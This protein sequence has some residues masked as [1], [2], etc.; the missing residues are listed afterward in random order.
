MSRAGGLP[1]GRRRSLKTVPGHVAGCAGMFLLIW[2]GLFFIQGT[3]LFS[4]YEAAA[5]VRTETAAGRA[6]VHLPEEDSRTTRPGIRMKNQSVSLKKAGMSGRQGGNSVSINSEESS[7]TDTRPESDMRRDTEHT[8]DSDTQPETDLW[9]ETEELLSQLGMSELDAYLRHENI[10]QL[11]FSQLVQDLLRK[12]ISM[13]FSSIGNKIMQIV[14][15]DYREN[16]NAL[17]QIITLALAFS[18]ILQMTGSMQTSCL[19][20]LGFLG[21]YLILMLLLLKLFLIMTTAVE[22]FFDRLV[23]FMHLLQPVFCISMVFSTGSTSAGVYSELLLLLIYLI[24]LVFAKILLP[25]VQIY[26]VL[27]LV[28]HMMGEARF[29]RIAGL[30]SDGVGWCTRLFTTA[31][32]GLNI[33]Q[34]LLAPGIDGLKRSTFAGAVRSI[35]WLGQLA[36]SMSELF[37]GSAMLIKNSVGVAALVILVIISF[38]PLLKIGVFMLLYRGCAALMEPVADKRICAAV[39]G[40]G[41]SAALYLKLMFYAVLLFF[42]T[43]AI[44]CTAT[45]LT[46]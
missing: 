17:I 2:T 22:S 28:N 41:H 27:E 33:V 32:L 42:L 46:V 15:S 6:V 14:L 12:G 11:T 29:S 1:A 38:L 35:P 40:L 5:A 20:D 13:D 9:Q 24:D 19:S 21:V 16:R 23:E 25:A 44:I 31:V 10:G 7:G 39:A 45:A 8:Q 36:D 30:L 3:F 26:M 43:I 4:S 34:G 37:T 18:I